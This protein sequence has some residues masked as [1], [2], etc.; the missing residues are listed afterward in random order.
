MRARSGPRYQPGPAGVAVRF[1]Y[2]QLGK[3]YRWGAAGP[4]SFDCSGLT[5]ASWKAAGVGLPH[6]AALQWAQV[7]HLSRAELK[8]GDLVFYY[9]NIH[10]V[11]IYIGGGKGSHAPHDRAGGRKA[12]LRGA[13]P[14]RS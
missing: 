3:P 8:P 13:P 5:M 10:H 14:P 1:A 4:N 12:P 6:S 7:R 11:A 9:G 2:G